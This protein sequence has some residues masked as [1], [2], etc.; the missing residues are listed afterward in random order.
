MRIIIL[1]LCIL[2]NLNM[3]LPVITYI[4]LIIGW[5]PLIYLVIRKRGIDMAPLYTTAV[6]SIFL[7]NIVGSIVV[8]EPRLNIYQMHNLWTPHFFYIHLIQLFF[9]YVSA[10]VFLR[11]NIVMGGVE[12]FVSIRKALFF[13]LMFIFL[14][15]LVLNNITNN[16]P[17]INLSSAGVNSVLMNT[18]NEFFEMDFS[19]LWIYRIAIYL[20]PQFICI[21]LLLN[22]LSKRDIQSMAAF[23]VM[24]LF[25]IFLSLMFLHKTPLILLISSLFLSYIFYNRDYNLKFILLSLF[26][27]LLAIIG[28]YLLYFFSAFETEGLEYAKFIFLQI[29]NRIFGA[30][31][32]S[33]A[34]SILLVSNNNFWMGEAQSLAY[35][36]SNALEARNLS[37]D[38]HVN[39]HGYSGYAP[40]SALGSAYV[41]FGYIG[42]ILMQ[43]CFV[44]A[45]FII[46]KLLR[47]IKEINFRIA[48]TVIFMTKIMFI[49]MTSFADV[50]SSP[51]ELL[52][53][54]GLFL[55]YKISTIRFKNASIS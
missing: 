52:A 28:L 12:E 26:V 45:V 15:L 36:S 30:Y 5:L 31:P 43:I 55:L 8:A 3:N 33:T 46:E 37:V 18:R 41:D 47:M 9:F 10:P 50:L 7:F 6:V 54:I 24:F 14:V 48:L 27:L 35:L 49:S 53:F 20:L 42:V 17:L 51:I 34:E 32:I 23:F 16:A 44:N 1:T 2:L 38:I 19:Y 29:L 40:A 22:F 11:S 4:A 13:S 25:S 21:L 39:I